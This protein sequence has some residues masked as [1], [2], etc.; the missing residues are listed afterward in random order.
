VP[1]PAPGTPLRL[2][3]RDFPSGRPLVMAIVNR[4]PDSFYSGA[5]Q[6]PDDVAHRAV[7]TAV[8]QGADLVDVGGVRAGPGERVGTDEELR[9]V[10]PFLERVRAEHPGLPL[11]ID[12]WRSPV[13]RRACE[14]GIDLIND[15]WGGHD[16]G[17]VQVAAEG[18]AGL[19]CSH[20]G[21]ARPRT[22][23]HRVAHGTCPEAVLEEVLDSLTA[24]ARRAVAA[25]VDP[26]SVVVDPAPDFG[27][28]TWHG[29]MLLRN[30]RALAGLGHPLLIALS[31]KDLIG[32]TLGLGVDDRLE[33]T[34]AATAVAAWCGAGVFR[35][36]DV[37]ATRRVLDMVAALRG[38]RPPSSVLR[39]LA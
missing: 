12:T 33:G 35:T 6:Y 37:A 26:R 17:L 31:R 36:H 39:G 11:S 29:L 30:V 25:G 23:P 5:R 14:I 8:E 19:V 1:V 15:A 16:P 34:L 4:T 28:N 3:R 20:T 27:K 7:A 9:R 22:L 24:A 13:A 32:E 10:I 18:G 2:R 38:D 21:G